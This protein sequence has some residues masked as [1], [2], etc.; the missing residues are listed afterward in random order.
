VFYDEAI[1]AL[2]HICGQG[3]PGTAQ[4]GE[5]CFPTRGRDDARGEDG[6]V[7]GYGFKGTVQMLAFR[8]GLGPWGGQFS[9]GVDIVDIGKL[10][11]A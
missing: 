5:F 3:V 1:G 9:L 4:I 2:L 11:A 6:G 8:A 10:W 7:G